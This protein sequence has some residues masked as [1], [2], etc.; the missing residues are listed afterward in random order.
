[1]AADL[2]D[3]TVY[4]AA[5][6]P[7]EYIGTKTE[8]SENG[9]IRA[10][11]Q[12]VT[13][14]LAVTLYGNRIEQMKTLVC[15]YGADIKKGDKTKIDGEMYKIVNVL[16]YSTHTTAFAEWEGVRENRD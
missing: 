13:D 15:S 12:P 1:M 16:M 10:Q 3:V 6:S 14:K 8:Y 4:R 9:T 11:I 7:S 2:S 5:T